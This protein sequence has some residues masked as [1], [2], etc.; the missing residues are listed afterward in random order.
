MCVQ[1][2]HCVSCTL[3]SQYLTKLPEN[4]SIIQPSSEHDSQWNMWD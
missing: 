2:T 1:Y 3:Q 4:Y